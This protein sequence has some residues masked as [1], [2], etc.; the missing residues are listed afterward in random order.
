MKNS[1]RF[2]HMMNAQLL[3]DL[4]D[5]HKV[6]F[7]DSCAVRVFG[8]DTTILTQKENAAGLFL[9]AYGTIEVSFLSEDG[10]KSIIYHATQG[11]M[12]GAIEAIAERP[13]AASCT[14]FANTTVLFCATSLL[15]EQLK[16][17]VFIRNIAT[18]AHD[19]MVRDNMFKSVD[20]FYTVEQRICI[21]LRYLSTPNS[22]FSQSQSYLANA[23]GCSRQT[24]NKELGRLRDLD[25]ID[26]DKGVIWVKDRTALARRIQDLDFSQSGLKN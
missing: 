20:Q 13:C 26:L 18:V 23:V 6:A 10:N 11:E 2:P 7:L 22:K 1:V 24:V 9:I 19:V 15:F 14:A 4:P 25:I 3:N 17:P 16:S 5:D 21:Y 8:E 12:L